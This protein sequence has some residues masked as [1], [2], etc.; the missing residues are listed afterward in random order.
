MMGYAKA[1]DEIID[2][3]KEDTY[4]KREDL[5]YAE[6]WQNGVG[7][8]T[9]EGLSFKSREERDA[10]LKKYKDGYGEVRASSFKEICDRLGDDFCI[11]LNRGCKG[12]VCSRKEAED[13]LRD[14][15]H[16]E[17][18]PVKA[19]IRYYEDDIASAEVPEIEELRESIEADD[20]IEYAKSIDLPAAAGYAHI[21]VNDV[22]VI[23]VTRDGIRNLMRNVWI[24][25]PE[26]NKN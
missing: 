18:Y 19:T 24:V 21:Y 9:P 20:L 26:G 2:I 10:W 7:N 17:Y 25:E 12:H 16:I 6:H 22:P 1:Q 15:K 13:I 11:L 5:F 14:L 4:V 8:G 23:A 3:K